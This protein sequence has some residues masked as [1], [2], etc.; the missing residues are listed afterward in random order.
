MRSILLSPH[1][2][3]SALFAAF[4]CQREKP[5]IVVCLDSWI[6][7]NRGELGCSAGE[8]AAENAAA[9]AYFRCE[10]LR[11]GLRDDMA[12]TGDEL[13]DLF[14][15]L[16]GTL[17]I[18]TVYAPAIQGGNRHHDW[19]AET[20]LQVF[21]VKVRQYTTYTKTELWTTG[22]IEIVP[23]ER[24]LE[25]KRRALDCYASQWR[26]NRAHFE[27]VIGKSEWLL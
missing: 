10:T 8:R 24:E 27:A 23:T 11:L 21:G 25:L 12:T 14:L 6:Q 9:H 17:D 2:D 20:A 13:A 16:A 5:L 15:E 7:P 4:T 22:N 3:D 18:D 1:D 26:I 19:V